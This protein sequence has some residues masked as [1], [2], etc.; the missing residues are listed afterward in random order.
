[1]S[2]G[3]LGW[4]YLILDA[5][6]YFFL[7]SN[8]I[9]VLFLTFNSTFLFLKERI[10]K[11]K[12]TIGH[13][14]LFSDERFPKISIIIP[15]YNEALHVSSTITSSFRQEY[16]GD[17]EIIVVDDGSRDRTWSIGKIFK[18]NEK[19][20]EV[21][22]FHKPNGGKASALRFGISRSSGDI[23]LMTDG[24]SGMHPRAVSSIV[25]TFRKYPDAGIVGGH[26]FI[27]NTHTGY[28]TKLQQL[29]YIITQHLIRINQSSDGNVL[30]AP[31][32]IFGMRTDLAKAMPPLERTIVEDCDLTMSI[33]PTRFSTR[34]TTKALS[35]TTAPISWPLWFRQRRRWIYGQF[36][37]WRENKWHLKRNPWGL[38]TY[39]TWVTTTFS[40]IMLIFTAIFTITLLLAGGDFYRFLEFISVRTF[41]VFI[42]YLSSRLLVL[43]QY[44]EGRRMIPFLPL[45][46]VYDVVNGI[47]TAYLYVMYITGRGIK[48]KWGNRYGVVQ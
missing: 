4:M 22:V 21:H 27:R 37:A 34:S 47:F 42:V 2:G 39:F 43:L 26:V 46:V 32:P 25:E 45:K 6:Y 18:T 33:L 41:F 20:R 17:I 36:Q 23:I 5:Y 10:K 30:I 15:C 44:E 29:E 8:L 7:I 16:R 24:D 3:T 28:L 1:M 40:S 12:K 38:Y 35:Y 48:I 31:G 13:S 9:P 11:R 14:D 19:G